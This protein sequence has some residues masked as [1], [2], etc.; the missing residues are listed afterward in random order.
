MSA[1]PAPMHTKTKRIA[2]IGQHSPGTGGVVLATAHGRPT[3]PPNAHP[4][5]PATRIAAVVRGCPTPATE[6][7]QDL[8][9]HALPMPAPWSH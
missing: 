2:A 6:G 3:T 4:H 9:M 7:N 8:E 5:T 1:L